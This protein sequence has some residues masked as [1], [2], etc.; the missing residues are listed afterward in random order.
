MSQ[1]TREEQPKQPSDD[2]ELG[3]NG[4]RTPYPIGEPVDP[5][6]SGPEPEYFPGKPGGGSPKVR[7][8]ACEGEANTG[9]PRLLVSWHQ[10]H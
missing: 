1:G 10:A 8:V 5:R 4:P 7:T 2:P 9:Q 3:P 6:G